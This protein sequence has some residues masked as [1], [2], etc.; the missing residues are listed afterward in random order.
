M[1]YLRKIEEKILFKEYWNNSIYFVKRPNNNSSICIEKIGDNYYKPKTSNP[2]SYLDY[3]I[4]P[5]L[6]HNSSNQKKDINGKF[7]LISKEF[8]YFGKSPISIPS[9]ICPDI[10][11]GQ[12]AHGIETKDKNRKQ[13]FFEYLKN[14]FK[15]GI[16]DKPHGWEDMF[17][18]DDSWRLDEN[19][20]KP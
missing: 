12:S 19:Y 5:N 10:P 18:N 7:V 6:H 1:I 2:N 15:I 20:I 4:M 16:Y 13:L 8:Y 14:N 11:K 9:N 17:G 3:E